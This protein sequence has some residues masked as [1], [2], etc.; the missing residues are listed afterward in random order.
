[1]PFDPLSFSTAQNFLMA[2]RA[3]RVALV[4]RRREELYA[5]LPELRALDAELQT[6]M[7]RAIRASFT[8][9]QDGEA[10]MARCRAQNE[11]L[12]QTRAALLRAHGHDPSAL[13]D[14]PDCP[15]C[16]DT[17]F[18]AG[19]LCACLRELYAR[20]LTRV[21]Q[22]RLDLASQT[23]ESFDP[24][25]FS[26][27]MEDAE[28]TSPRDNM[29]LLHEF[30]GRFAER[31]GPE[32]P[33]LLFTGPPGT[34][35]TFLSACV[36]GALSA[37]GIWCE[38]ISAP[39]LFSLLEAEKFSRDAGASDEVRRFY[40]CDLLLLDD[41]GSEFLSPFVQSAFYHLLNQRLSGR[42]KMVLITTLESLSPRYTP[43]IVSR[44][45]GAFWPLHFFG[46]DLRRTL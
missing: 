28:E 16:D 35:K 34:G 7:I 13:D 23:F 19:R 44:V 17:G 20:E 4:L 45:D 25:V 43:Q 2:R 26:P 32:S 6:N 9:G 18:A 36:A 11:E 8:D 14:T 3:E 24:D 31:F 46:A 37:R 42:G 29:V 15:L 10:A 38:Y 33:N 1:M 12:E 39:A 22:T 30:C 41:L 21:L 5:A 27:D 40:D